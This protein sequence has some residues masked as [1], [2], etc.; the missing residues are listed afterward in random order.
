MEVFNELNTDSK[1][2]ELTI[3]EKD[4]NMEDKSDSDSE[5]NIPDD[6]RFNNVFPVYDNDTLDYIPE[7]TE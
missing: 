1:T 6:A 5:F 3:G 7:D 4:K 2:T